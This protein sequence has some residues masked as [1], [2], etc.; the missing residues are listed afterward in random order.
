M[1]VVMKKQR[2]KNVIWNILTGG[3]GGDEIFDKGGGGIRASASNTHTLTVPI[4]FVL[5]A[6]LFSPAKMRKFCIHNATVSFPLH[7]VCD[8]RKLR[9]KL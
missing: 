8:L 5:I 7:C 4:F 6:H 3:G 9:T 2:E 1:V